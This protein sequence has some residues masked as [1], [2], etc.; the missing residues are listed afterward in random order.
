M[1]AIETLMS[2][3]SVPARLLREPAPE[4]RELEEI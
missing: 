1:D 2:R 3:N 4:G